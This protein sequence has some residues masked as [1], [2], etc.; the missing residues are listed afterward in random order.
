MRYWISAIL[1]LTYMTTASVSAKES[2]CVQCHLSGEW[3]SDTAIA[4]DFVARDIH[5]HAGLDCSDCHGG[6]PSLGFEEGEP[7]LAMDPAKGYRP[8]PGKLGVPDFCARC[9]SDIEYMKKYNPRLAVDQLQLYKTSTHGKSLYGKRD[10]KVAVCTD[11]HRTH[12][13][14]PPSDSRSKVYHNNVPLT[15]KSCHSDANLMK[16]Y[17]Y[18]GMQF[19]TDQFEEYRQSVHGLR[20]LEEGDKSTPACNGCHGNHGATPPQLSS[21]SAACGECHANNRDF[22]R[23][24]PHQDPWAELDIPECEQCHG[25]H[26]VRPTTDELLGVGEASSCTECHEPDSPGYAAAAKMKADIDSLKATL[27]LAEDLISGAENKGVEGGQAR[28]DLGRAEDALTRVRSVIHTFD[29]DEVAAI[30]NPAIQNARQVQRTAG[31][32]LSDIR[33]RQIGLG[34]SLILVLLVVF[35]LWKKMKEVDSRTDFSARE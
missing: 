25:N 16:G 17:R 31:S 35:L 2:S 30:V 6:D 13:I 3:V 29:P 33:A 22:F 23:K 21:V 32:A 1:A 18:K 26:S 27:A 7:G 9:H 24:S 19:P 34:M 20:V 12:G 8:P 14:L 15:C 28:F 11:C 4:S 10:T 5:Y